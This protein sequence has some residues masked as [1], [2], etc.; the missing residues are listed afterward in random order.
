MYIQYYKNL[1]KTIARHDMFV[2]IKA[3]AS[4][5]VIQLFEIRFGS[6]NQNNHLYQHLSMI[7]SVSWYLRDVF[8]GT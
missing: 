6:D 4:T 7:I 5:G 2:K 1:S 8:V 3:K